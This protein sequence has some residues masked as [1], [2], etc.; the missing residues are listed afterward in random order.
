[1]IP[2]LIWEIIMTHLHLNTL[3]AGVKDEKETK[4]TGMISRPMNFA[5]S[6]KFKWNKKN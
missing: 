6:K 1:M 4:T 3:R 2:G 5:V